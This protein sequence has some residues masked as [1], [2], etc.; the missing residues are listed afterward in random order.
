M[1]E[2]AGGASGAAA[3]EPDTPG[4]MLRVERERR[5]YSVQHVAEELHLDIR[6]IE[7]LETNRFEALGA[8][9]Y[10]R[11]HLRKY[12]T[13]LGLSPATVL[14]RYEALGGTPPDPTPVPAVMAVPL[15]VE[16][17]RVSKLPLWIA[18]AIVIVA[19]LAW[20]VFQLLQARGA[21]GTT[22][23]VTAPT[24]PQQPTVNESTTL[25]EPTTVTEPIAQA[26]APV[27]QAA[28]QASSPTPAAVRL[29]L[30]FIEPSWTEIYDASGKRLM[31]DMGT[32]G[33]V[34]SV[35]GTPP[36]RVS[37][38]LVSAVNAQVNDRPIVVPR[39]AGWD[40]TKFVIEADGSVR[41]DTSL[42]TAER[43]E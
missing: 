9:V 21:I 19:G 25:T 28:P 4:G 31:F 35:A 23:A 7:A 1:N 5:G 32:P 20:L 42:K 15:R 34:R 39:R 11:G 41:P 12:A 17:R 38:G 26:P 18:A 24:A 6:V 10:A 14:A 33:R 37:L 22:S 29:R 36:L 43:V 13:L 40:S 8:P 27:A 30:E 3:A 16:R 2:R